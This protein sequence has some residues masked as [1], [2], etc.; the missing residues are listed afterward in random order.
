MAKLLRGEA[1]KRGSRGWKGKKPESKKPH[2]GLPALGASWLFQPGWS[3]VF[4]AAGG[5]RTLL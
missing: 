3:R 2:E 4:S 5:H 1:V